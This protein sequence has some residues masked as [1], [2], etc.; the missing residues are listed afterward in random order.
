MDPPRPVGGSTS[1]GRGASW[2]SQEGLSA[3]GISALTALVAELS[4]VSQSMVLVVCVCQKF[5]DG[6]SLATVRVA[7]GTSED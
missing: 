1:V 4:A 5:M 2:P 7:N 6:S 3:A